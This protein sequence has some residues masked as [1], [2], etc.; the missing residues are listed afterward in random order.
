MPE[1]HGVVSRDLRDRSVNGGRKARGFLLVLSHGVVIALSKALKVLR[2][3]VP[4]AVV[5]VLVPDVV[6][7]EVSVAQFFELRRKAE[8]EA[9]GDVVLVVVDRR[10]AVLPEE[11]LVES[12]GAQRVRIDHVGVFDARSLIRGLVIDAVVLAVLRISAF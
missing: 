10:E 4:P 1:F 11:L 9:E 5:A 6:G 8:L 2:L 7:V 3:R 12:Q